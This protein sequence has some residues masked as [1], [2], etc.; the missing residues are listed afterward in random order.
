MWLFADRLLTSNVSYKLKCLNIFVYCLTCT[1]LICF[2]QIGNDNVA[3]RMSYDRFLLIAKSLKYSD[4]ALDKANTCE[5]SGY[6][7]ILTTNEYFN[8][9]AINEKRS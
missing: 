7:R 4:R 2:R 5:T 8:D 3:M 1:A 9:L 6:L